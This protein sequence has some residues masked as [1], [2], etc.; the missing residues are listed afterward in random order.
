MSVCLRLLVLPVQVAPIYWCYEH[1]STNILVLPAQVAPIYWCYN[2]VAPI[3]WCY[4]V[5][6]PIYCC[7]LCWQH[8]YQP[9][10]ICLPH[11]KV[12]SFLRIFSL[13]RMGLIRVEWTINNYRTPCFLHGDWFGSTPTPSPISKGRDQWE[14]STHEIYYYYWCCK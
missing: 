3:Y 7:Y 6:A 2:V 1:R 11:G 13:L 8:Q 10:Q 12:Y 9:K 5:V 14:L 4:D